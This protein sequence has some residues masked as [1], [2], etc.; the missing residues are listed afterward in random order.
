MGQ[1]LVTV[2]KLHFEHGVGQGF[3]DL[4]FHRDAFF[5]SH[6][7]QSSRVIISGSPAVTMTVSSKC[8]ERRRSLVIT[9]QP[10]DSTSTAATPAFTMGSIAKV[11]PAFNFGPR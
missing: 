9:V 3:H 7:P 10:S 6:T 5:L 8:A 2:F 11:M 1:N 4:A